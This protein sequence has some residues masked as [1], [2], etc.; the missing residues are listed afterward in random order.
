[1]RM[2]LS[3]SFQNRIAAGDSPGR[4]NGD[5]PLKNVCQAP[6][7]TEGVIAGRRIVMYCATGIRL[8]TE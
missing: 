2:V 4:K 5:S 3:D 7:Q 8:W 1:M 6:A